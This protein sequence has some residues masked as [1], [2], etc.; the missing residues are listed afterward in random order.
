[1]ASWRLPKTSNSDHPS[2]FRPITLCQT[3]YK[4]TAKIL[5]NRL[6][7]ILPCLISEEQAAFVHGRS[8]SAHCLLGQE[9]M[10]KFKA[11][12][13]NSG[14]LAMKVDME[15]AYDKMSWRALKLV[16]AR[17]GFPTRF[18]AWVLNCICDPQFSIL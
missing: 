2:M 17:M 18:R 5:V 12:K 16:L 14:W 15:Q 13:S 4:I 1:M 10:H 3:I 6:K 9:I 7:G 8:I 11:S